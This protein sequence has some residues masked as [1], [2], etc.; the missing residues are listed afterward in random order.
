MET[1]VSRKII[2]RVWASGTTA[3]HGKTIGSTIKTS[4][5]EKKDLSKTKKR[6]TDLSFSWW[7]C[8]LVLAK[9][10]VSFLS[11]RHMLGQPR[12][13]T[14]FIAIATNLDLIPSQKRVS[15]AIGR[16]TFAVFGINHVDDRVAKR[17]KNSNGC[18]ETGRG[19]HFSKRPGPQCAWQIAVL[20]MILAREMRFNFF[21][22]TKLWRCCECRYSRYWREKGDWNFLKSAKLWRCC[23]CRWSRYWREKCDWKLFKLTKLWKC[24]ECR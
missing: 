3:L 7:A 20:V 11:T 21:K 14:L 13:S 17:F 8:R 22:S 4:R 9:T 24:C 15:E 23:Q 16:H 6:A 5:K 10:R 1:S 19:R 12:S 18:K 2:F